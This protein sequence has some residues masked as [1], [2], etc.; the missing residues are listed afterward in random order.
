MYLMNNYIE[1][2]GNQLKYKQ[3]KNPDMGGPGLKL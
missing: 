1:I 3:T 2:I